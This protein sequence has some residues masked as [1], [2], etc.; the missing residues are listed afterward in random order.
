MYCGKPQ[1]IYQ[2]RKPSYCRVC[3]KVSYSASGIHPQCAQTEA[4]Q[5]RV[6]RQ[7][8]TAKTT[9]AKLDKSLELKPWH[10]RCPKCRTQ[11]HIRKKTCTCGHVLKHTA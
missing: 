10:N 7:K 11:V 1:P 8:R 5:K 4:D 9:S 6:N 3:G 2:V